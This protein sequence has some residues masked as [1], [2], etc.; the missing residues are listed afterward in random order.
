MF[1]ATVKSAMEYAQQ[2]KVEEWVHE[3]LCGEGNNKPFSDGLKLKKRQ[4]TPPA[5]MKLDLL[6]R[7]HGPESDMKYRVVGEEH[8]GYFRLKI[9]EIEQRYAAGNWDMP[10]LIVQCCDEIYELNDGNHRIEAL[11]NLK[12]DEYWVIL[13]K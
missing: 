6:T 12:I 11:K 4:F 7:I 5:L 3:F 1:E 13:W 9:E 8:I 10:P 2:N